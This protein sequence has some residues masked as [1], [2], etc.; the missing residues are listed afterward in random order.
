M[1]N[2]C[3]LDSD[4]LPVAV[5]VN[6]EKIGTYI[7]GTSIKVE[8][9]FKIKEPDYYFLLSWNFL[10]TFKLKPV[11]RQ[12]ARKFVVPVPHPFISE[13]AETK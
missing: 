9:E 3:E 2:F 13:C 10:E 11:Y 6:K 8:D 1:V 7:P 4:I 12:G 5:E